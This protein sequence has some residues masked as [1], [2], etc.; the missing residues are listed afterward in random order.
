MSTFA[1]KITALILMFLDHAGLYFEGAPMWFRWV[2]RASYPLF[3]FSMVW[4]YHYTRDRKKIPAS[5]IPDEYFYDL[6]YLLH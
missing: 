4:G 6:F 3:L 5:F 1:L 2:G